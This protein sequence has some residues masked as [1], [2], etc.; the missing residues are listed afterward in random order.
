M[1]RDNPMSRQLS[2]PIG[3]LIDAMTRLHGCDNI[4][5]SVH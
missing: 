2:H 5:L 3:E 1:G 4:D